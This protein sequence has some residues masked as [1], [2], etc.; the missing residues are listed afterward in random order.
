M[1]CF[2][3][4]TSK[5]SLQNL[6]WTWQTKHCGANIQSRWI[7]KELPS[8]RSICSRNTHQTPLPVRVRIPAIP[9]RP[10]LRGRGPS[11][12]ARWFQWKICWGPLDEQKIPQGGARV[13]QPG[14]QL[15]N[16]YRC[17]KV[18]VYQNKIWPLRVGTNNEITTW[19]LHVVTCTYMSLDVITYMPHTPACN[20]I[21]HDGSIGAP[22]P[23]SNYMHLHATY[24][25]LHA[26]Y[27]PLTCNYMPLTT[28]PK[29]L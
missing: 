8:K 22:P 3:C 2:S 23:T 11:P 27:I 21:T 19:G 6:C 17:N 13:V 18:L 4:S 28:N 7:K 29:C 1:Q 20:Y 10:W 15:P 24:M 9:K 16:L 5:C 12:C 14:M 25:H 26:T